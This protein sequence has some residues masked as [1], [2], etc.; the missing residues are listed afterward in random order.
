MHSDDIDVET[1]PARGACQGQAQAYVPDT[2]GPSPLKGTRLQLTPRGRRPLVCPGG[3]GSPDT[4][5][6]AAT[7]AGR[8]GADSGRSTVERVGPARAQL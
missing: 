7:G 4:Y 8:L 1:Y 3:G 5:L 6:P 2:T